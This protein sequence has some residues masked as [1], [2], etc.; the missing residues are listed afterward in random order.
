[1]SVVEEGNPATIKTIYGYGSHYYIKKI[2]GAKIDNVKDTPMWCE[3]IHEKNMGN[4]AYFLNAKMVKEA[5]GFGFMV[6]DCSLKYGVG[7]YLFRFLPRY[8]K[9][10]VKRVGYRLYGRQW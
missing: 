1:M 5:K 2:P 4:D 7:V 6:R 9:T 3:V 8:C 10:F